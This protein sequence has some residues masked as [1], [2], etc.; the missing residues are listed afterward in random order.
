MWDINCQQLNFIN[1]DFWL[2]HN[3]TVQDLA[4]KNASVLYGS[5]LS[6]SS[7]EQLLL[8]LSCPTKYSN[9]YFNNQTDNMMMNMNI[10]L[11]KAIHKCTG[12]DI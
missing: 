9:N 4:G 10:I 3:S 1:K 6:I 8:S 11:L 2:F 12:R 5:A 7:I